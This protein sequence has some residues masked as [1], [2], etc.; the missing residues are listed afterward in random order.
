M[1][2][3]KSLSA[4]ALSKV[5]IQLAHPGSAHGYLD[6][7]CRRVVHDS[8]QHAVAGLCPRLAPCRSAR[9]GT[10]ADVN[11]DRRVVQFDLDRV[12]GRPHGAR[13][14]DARRRR[15][16]RR[17]CGDLFR[18]RLVSFVD[19]ING[20]HRLV[21]CQLA[22]LGPDRHPNLFAARVSRPGHRDFHMGLL[23]VGGMLVGV[24]SAAI[25]AP[26]ATSTMSIVGTLCMIAIYFT[27][28]RRHLD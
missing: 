11:G 16:L 19:G 5:E 28:S 23:L 25:G 22:R 1:A 26:W 20:D 10:V 27:H 17:A 14:F 2:G 3:T 9:A 8:V 21:P 4:K 6:C 18:V 13:Y 24:L 12:A 15:S 7:D